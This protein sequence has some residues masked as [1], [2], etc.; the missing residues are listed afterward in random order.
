MCILQSPLPSDEGLRGGA[1]LR[2][3]HSSQGDMMV[4]LTGVKVLV[5]ENY[6]EVAVGQSV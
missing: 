1:G 4:T 6:T 2:G 5:M 3:H